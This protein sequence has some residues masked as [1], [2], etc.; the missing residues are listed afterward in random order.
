M[1]E[2]P[3][4]EH[5]YS[6]DAIQTNLA[7]LYGKSA[8]T[9]GTVTKPQL[10]TLP[11][12]AI[13]LFMSGSV[14][15]GDNGAG[16]L[17]TSQ[18][19]TSAG[20]MAIQDA[21]GRWFQ[22]VLNDI[23]NA[24]WFNATG[25]GVTDDTPALQ[26][27]VNYVVAN[28]AHGFIPAGTY[29]LTSAL[30]VGTGYGWTI[31]GAGESAE[32]GLGGVILEQ[33]TNNTQIFIFTQGIWGF[34]FYR[35]FFRWS[36][37]QPAT[38]TNAVALYFN[39]SCWNIT[40]DHCH[41]DRGFRC[42][43]CNPLATSIPVWGITINKCTK[44]QS[45]SGAFLYL[46]CISMPGQPNII[47]RDNYARCDLA[48][49]PDILVGAAD[50]MVIIGHEFNGGTYSNFPQLSIAGTNVTI[51]AS[52]SEFPTVTGTTP[53]QG[54][55]EFVNT[56]ATLIGCE[57]IALSIN[58]NN[59][60]AIFVNQRTFDSNTHVVNI[61][62]LF[63]SLGVSGA[64]VSV[65]P[66][67]GNVPTALGVKTD[68]LGNGI[69]LVGPMLPYQDYSANASTSAST[70][71]A[72][73]DIFGTAL[74]EHTLELTGAITAASN[75]QLPTA[76]QLITAMGANTYPARGQ[77]YKLRV[78]NG[79]VSGSGIWT[80]TTNAGWTLNGLTTIAPGKYRD[81]YIT[82]AWENVTYGLLDKAALQSV[83][84]T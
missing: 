60:A 83:G 70:V 76:A 45:V 21:S 56:E 54:L 79:A 68:A 22:L 24:G 67:N 11:L 18:G 82:L 4:T 40:I 78:I 43:A 74:H 72:A 26:K 73:A 41:F 20:P 37:N 69:C 7:D 38:N 15:P 80:L 23:V 46:N 16:A 31:E 75:A 2:L 32:I 66:Y 17:Y 84:G 44:S 64:S 55:W 81:F 47:L 59:A 34:N 12:G 53:L 27:F 5:S 6:F 48:T 57:L 25:N 1:A 42:I 36:T 52:K 62:G 13:T 19:A 65:I 28:G 71:L 35:I 49:E 50:N 33:V 10:P 8:A 14:V 29:L 9:V 30:T 58:Q 61:I 63:V 51:I 3:I 39:A 77:S